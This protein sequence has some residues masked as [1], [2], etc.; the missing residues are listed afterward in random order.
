VPDQVITELVDEVV[1]PLL[2]AAATSA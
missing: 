1:L 2:R